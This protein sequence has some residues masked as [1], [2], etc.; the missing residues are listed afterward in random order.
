[1][2]GCW[3]NYRTMKRR[4]ASGSVPATESTTRKDRKSPRRGSTMLVILRVCDFFDVVKNRGCKQNSYDDKLV[5][6]SKKSQTLS[7]ARISLREI[8]AKSKD[9]YS[10]EALSG[11]GGLGQ[12]FALRRAACAQDGSANF[13]AQRID[14]STS[15]IHSG[16][17][18]TSSGLGPSAAPT[19]PSRSIRSIR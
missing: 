16:R 6:N 9:P 10:H 7:G 3:P 14:S 17:L 4:K 12:H 5:I 8:L 19:M 18:S 15:E 11:V 2:R 13:L 1:M